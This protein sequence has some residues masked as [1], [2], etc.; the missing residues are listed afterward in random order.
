MRLNSCAN[1]KIQKALKLISLLDT[2]KL[3]Y[4]AP[5]IDVFFVLEAHRSAGAED[6]TSSVR[7]ERMWR[8]LPDTQRNTHTVKSS[9]F[10]KGFNYV[11]CSKAALH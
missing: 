4:K 3:I 5:L 9:S 2:F 8:L 7:V 1:Q 11:D 6:H 10:I